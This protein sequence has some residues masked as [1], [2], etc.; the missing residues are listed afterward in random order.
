MDIVTLQAAVAASSRKARRGNLLNRFTPASANPFGVTTPTVDTPA[1]TTGSSATVT[2]MGILPLSG[3]V[4]EVGSR[5]TINTTFNRHVVSGGGATGLDFY[6]TGST[7]ELQIWPQSSG[8]LP[9]WVWVN[10][11]P[12]TASVDAVTVTSGAGLFVKLIFP[13]VARRR[14]E[15]F[16]AGGAGLNAWYPLVVDN[17]SLVTPAPRRPVVGFVGDSF[18]DG[19]AA[20][21]N[22]LS[23]PFL[24]SRLLGVECV[25]ASWGGTGYVATGA[26]Q[27]FGSATRTGIMSKAEVELIVISG[28]VNDDGS[29]ATLGAAATATYSAYATACPKAPII[30]FGPQPTNA[31]ATISPNRSAAITAVKSAAL[32]APNVLAFADMCG[33][34]GSVP[35]AYNAGTTY[36]P[37]DLCTHKG[38]VWKNVSGAAFSNSTPGNSRWAL[39]TWSYF[40]TGQVGTTV[41]DGTRDTYLYSDGVHPTPE[42]NAAFAIRQASAIRAALALA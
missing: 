7:V 10:G 28:S 30:V 41:G 9:M 33:T 17:S 14:I 24:I 22:L 20:C 16:F 15:I 26:F 40:G 34:A 13:T 19:S 6:L 12:V 23:A 31:T 21:T 39:V 29:F 18:F 1:I 36:Q 8:S 38:S 4:T 37:N 3:L 5:G 35:A 25:S 27:T 32:A 11:V 2:G 42:A